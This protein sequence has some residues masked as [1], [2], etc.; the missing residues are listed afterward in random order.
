MSRY[1]NE[2]LFMKIDWE[3]GIA[4]AIE[5]GIRSSDVPVDLAP[6]WESASE[7]YAA[8]SQVADV[9]MEILEKEYDEGN[10]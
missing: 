3:G 6:L 9:I 1:T 7:R 5:Y 8:F 10:L 2:D 4:E